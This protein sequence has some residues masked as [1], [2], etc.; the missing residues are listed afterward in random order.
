M[1]RKIA[2]FIDDAGYDKWSN[3][4]KL[5]RFIRDEK[6]EKVTVDDGF[7]VEPLKFSIF[8]NPEL[9]DELEDS[10]ETIL[11]FGFGYQSYGWPGYVFLVS[12]VVCIVSLI[13]FL[14]YV[15]FTDGASDI[16]KVIF[17]V[18]LGLSGGAMLITGA[19]NVITAYRNYRNYFENPRVSNLYMDNVKAADLTGTNLTEKQMAKKQAAREIVELMDLIMNDDR[20]GY[21]YAI[22]YFGKMRREYENEKNK[23]V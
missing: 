2:D 10:F 6:L 7:I 8:T 21:R 17:A 15:V 9:E 3:K 13:L 20:K 19:M 1:F 14:V 23:N 16:V 11:D 4:K 22:Q 18:M 5:M 12:I